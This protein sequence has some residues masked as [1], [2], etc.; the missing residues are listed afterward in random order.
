MHAGGELASWRRGG[1]ELASWRRAGGL[2]ASWRPGGELASWR[3]AG[4]EL[5][6]WRR[7]GFTRH[8]TPAALRSLAAALLPPNDTKS[9]AAL[10][11][12][13]CTIG[14]I[15]VCFWGQ[16][17]RMLVKNKYPAG[18]DEDSTAPPPGRL[19]PGLLPARV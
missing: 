15:P 7:A 9:V 13:C 5:A 4:G 8:T 3:R 12:P 17:P 16:D 18:E 6:S 10:L 19:W 14:G 2:A 1:G 11:Q